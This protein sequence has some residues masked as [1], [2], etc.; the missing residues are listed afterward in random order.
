MFVTLFTYWYYVYALIWQFLLNHYGCSTY[1]V[2]ILFKP[3][4][5][6]KFLFREV[7]LYIKEWPWCNYVGGLPYTTQYNA[8][9][10]HYFIPSCV[11][12]MRRSVLHNCPL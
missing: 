8:I 11:F 7:F 10:Y 4:K 9:K 6:A 1:S 2:N 12:V 3:I 5:C